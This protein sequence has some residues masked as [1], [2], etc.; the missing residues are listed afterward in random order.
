M[1]YCALV[2]AII[3]D[4]EWTPEQAFEAVISNRRPRPMEAYSTSKFSGS[5]IR[6]IRTAGKIK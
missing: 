2:F 4:E 5:P 6:K 1:N 3:S